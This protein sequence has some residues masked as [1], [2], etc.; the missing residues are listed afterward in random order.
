MKGPTQQILGLQVEKVPQ[1]QNTTSCAFRA[2]LQ[3]PLKARK[4]FVRGSYRSEIH[5]IRNL[6]ELSCQR[7]QS[8]Y[9][10]LAC[11]SDT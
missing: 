9:T 11:V 1:I 7:Q 3:E 8:R 2:G 10:L 6:L 4:E 5:V